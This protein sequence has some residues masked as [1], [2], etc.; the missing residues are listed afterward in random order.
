MHP[1]LFEKD[2]ELAEFK[3]KGRRY[4]EDEKHWLLDKQR[5]AAGR[6]SSRCTAS[7]PTAARSS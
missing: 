7:S 3:A 1:L 5:D 2:P 6:R 4:T